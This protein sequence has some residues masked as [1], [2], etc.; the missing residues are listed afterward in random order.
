MRLPGGTDN[1]C[2]PSCDECPETLAEIGSLVKGTLFNIDA[3]SY[4]LCGLNRPTK[5]SCLEVKDLVLSVI[6]KISD[7]LFPNLKS[8]TSRSLSCSHLLGICADHDSDGKDLE[9]NQWSCNSCN[10]FLNAGLSVLKTP[11]EDINRAAAT[12]FCGEQQECNSEFMT[13]IEITGVLGKV[14]RE[15]KA[16]D[17]VCRSVMLCKG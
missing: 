1:F 6:G 7:E 5:K 12:F 16:I 15:K 2:Y 4:R 17:E 13:V 9:K 14:I 3:T 8:N 10:T 11:L